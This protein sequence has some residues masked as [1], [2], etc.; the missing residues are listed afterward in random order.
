MWALLLLSVLGFVLFVER[1]LYLHKGQIRSG[2]FLEGIKNLLEKRR[3]LE[4]ITV[5]QET[6]GPVPRVVVAALRNFR[7]SEA[8]IRA[9]MREAALVE[10]PILER[11]VGSLAAIA[12]VAPL[13]GLLGTVVAM[14]TA[15]HLMGEAGSYAD[16]SLFSGQ[17]ARA[18][19]TTA[20]GLAISAVAYLAHHFL[21]GRIRA[22]V[23][24]MEW[25]CNDLLQYL[26]Q[27]GWRDVEP[28]ANS[29]DKVA[30]DSMH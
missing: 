16:A 15:F 23:H 4:A 9:A 27:K 2:A 19:I 8:E 18:L 13:I 25:A 7:R 30:V 20:A 5:C 22:L 21:S 12:K 3:L 10:I 24:D 11:R 14:L 1:T 29:D 6:P 26:A 17:V 28:P